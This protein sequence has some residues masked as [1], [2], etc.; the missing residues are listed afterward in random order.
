MWH[1][2]LFFFNHKTDRFWVLLS[3]KC[4]DNHEINGERTGNFFSGAFWSEKDVKKKWDDQ[5]A[6]QTCRIIWN[7][8]G[9]R[10]KLFKK[11]LANYAS[12]WGLRLLSG[13]MCGQNRTLV[14]SQPSAPCTDMRKCAV[15]FLVV[16]L[17]L[18]LLSMSNSYSTSCQQVGLWNLDVE[19]GEWHSE[20][21]MF[22]GCSGTSGLESGT[23]SGLAPGSASAC[24]G[25]V[26]RYQGSKAWKCTVSDSGKYFLKKILAV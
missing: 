10:I 9:R 14:R 1:T 7:T 18:S 13:S 15:C 3:Q 2:I 26:I 6:R 11:C 23:T 19:N 8:N 4:C 17:L 20:I 24:K 5:C 22:W 25:K 16:L 21:L 12:V